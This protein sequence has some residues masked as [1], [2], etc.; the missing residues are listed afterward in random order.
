MV[1]GDETR[2]ALDSINTTTSARAESHLVACRTR[3]LGGHR[4]G[5]GFGLEA[6]LG[7]WESNPVTRLRQ[8][9]VKVKQPHSE[10]FISDKQ[11]ARTLTR[12]VTSLCVQSPLLRGSHFHFDNVHLAILAIQSSI[13]LVHP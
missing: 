7:R 1:S 2:M 6:C 13:L 8:S 12:T 10:S 4:P 11:R 9:A 5:F 3:C